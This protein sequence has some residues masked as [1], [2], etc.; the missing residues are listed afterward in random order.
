[1]A[2]SEYYVDPL[3]GDDTTGDG[4]TDATAWKTIQKALFSITQNTTDGDRINLKDSAT[5]VISTAYDFTS[6][7]GY[8]QTYPLVFQGYTSTAGD[9]GKGTIDAGGNAIAIFAARNYISYKDLKVGNCSTETGI[10][11]SRGAAIDCEV[12][13]AGIGIS[14]NQGFAS[15]N[16]IHDCTSYGISA[17][18]GGSLYANHLEN[19]AT[20]KF[21]RAINVS[22]IYSDTCYNTVSVDG[23]TYGIFFDSDPGNCYGNS[24]LSSGGTTYGIYTHKDSYASAFCGNL[25]EGYNSGGIGIGRNGTSSKR[26]VAAIAANSVFDCTT[27]FFDVD[28]YAALAY[29]NETLSVTPFAKSGANT[30]ANR[31]SYFEPVDTG[32]VYSGGLGGLHR[33]AV[34]PPAGGGGGTTYSLHPLAYN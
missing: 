20:K 12:H 5:E 28:D 26:S 19:G 10:A 3:N 31:L 21:T 17:A 16:Y 34:P 29:G 2:M 33:G 32:S 4:L 25:V 15:G 24:V 18:S 9:G 8:A 22:N 30:F 1:M 14:V 7:G 23:S 27:P 6:I 11:V 13:D